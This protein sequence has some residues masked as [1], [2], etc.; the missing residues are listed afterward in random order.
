MKFKKGRTVNLR[1]QTEPTHRGSK[2]QLRRA[3]EDTYLSLEDAQRQLQPHGKSKS[4]LSL[5]HAAYSHSH[6]PLPAMF[7]PVILRHYSLPSVCQ[8]NLE[9]QRSTH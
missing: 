1:L 4:P 2:E 3:T 7:A 9:V 8:S 6:P 5:S